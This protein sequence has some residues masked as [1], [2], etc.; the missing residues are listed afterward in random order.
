[1]CF[2]CN[3]KRISDNNTHSEGGIERLEMDYTKE[4]LVEWSK[5]C[6]SDKS[7]R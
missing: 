1:M 5:Y 2:I 4:H 3:D 7:S 6:E